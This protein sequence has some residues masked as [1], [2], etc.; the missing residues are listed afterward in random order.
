MASTMIDQKTNSNGVSYCL[1][2]DGESNTYAVY[3]L[4]ENYS[5]HAR[6]GIVKS[7]RYVEKQ[8]SQENAKK[9]FNRRTK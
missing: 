2:F 9:L 7:W 3:K 6:G 8:M 5:R 1:C 4:C